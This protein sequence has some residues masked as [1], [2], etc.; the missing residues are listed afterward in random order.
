MTVQSKEELIRYALRALGEPYSEVNVTDEQ[1]NDRLMDT[2]ERYRDFHYNGTQRMYIQYQLTADDIENKYIEIPDNITSVVR[3][4]PPNEGT[5][6]GISSGD[7][8]LFS[9]QYQVRMGDLWNI[10]TG[11]MAYYTA[12]MQNLSMLDQTF[13]GSPLIRHT[14]VVN[15][16]YIDAPLG[17]AL[18]AGMWVV[19]E[20]FVTT[21]PDEYRKVWDD[22]WV[23]EYFTALVQSQWGRNLSK[24][25]NIMLVGGVTINGDDIREDAE[26]KIEMLEDR[27][28]N[29]LQ[30][31]PMFFVG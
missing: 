19:F 26:Q 18:Q 3:V 5:A 25:G 15:K 1:I 20:C 17:R 10:T 4:F 11:T 8:G 7:A 31:P 9:V 28:R 16:L 2:L 12:M 30:E 6:S 13:N 22:P 21:D 23:K 14:Q 29:E 24:F 27:L